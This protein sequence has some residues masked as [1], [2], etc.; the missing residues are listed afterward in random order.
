MDETQP[1][2]ILVTGASGAGLSTALKILEDVGILAV[3]NLPLAMIDTLVALEVETGK[4][5]LAIGLDARTTGFSPDA[6]ETLVRNLR[7][8]FGAQFTSVF[9]SAS[10]DD[11]LRRFNATRRQHPLPHVGSLEEAI[12]A[13]LLRMDKVMPL[14]DIQIDTSAAK[15]S[16]LRQSLLS[17]L[18]MAE[19]FK[20]Q[21]RILSFSYRRRLPDHSDLVIDMR[22]ASNPHWVAEL[23]EPDGRDPSVIAY[24]NE[25]DVARDVIGSVKDMLSKMLP[26]MSL[27]GRPIVTVAFGCTGGKHRSVWASETIGQWLREQG[28][29]VKVAHRE[30]ESVT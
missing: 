6:V 2:L 20:I 16:D 1:R 12:S 9:L 14:A 22:F 4:R 10:H 27:E 24:L 21:V 18:D 7:R 3:D 15:P 30:I 13:D 25:D 8:K 29:S 28:Y 26:R 5:S 11:L 19:E 17:K 23:R